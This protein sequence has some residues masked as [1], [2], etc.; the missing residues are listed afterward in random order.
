MVTGDL[1]SHFLEIQDC[2]G[3]HLGFL[4][5]PISRSPTK[6]FS[7]KLIRRQILPYDGHWGLRITLLAKFEMVGI[8]IKIWHAR[9]EWVMITIRTQTV[10]FEIGSTEMAVMGHV[11]TLHR[12][13]PISSFNYAS[14][15]VFQFIFQTQHCICCILYFKCK[16][17][18]AFCIW[19]L[20]TLWVCFIF[21]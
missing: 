13:W 9:M 11:T 15:I 14:K 12:T 18:D 21:H 3:C 19:N 4:F 20:N 5:S 17:K 2:G 10:K 1:E 6:V 7:S 8:C 16:Y